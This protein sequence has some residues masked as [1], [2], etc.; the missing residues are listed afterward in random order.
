MPFA[1]RKNGRLI[2]LFT[3]ILGLLLSFV[4]LTVLRDYNPP[5]AMMV[6]IYWCLAIPNRI[7]IGT[8]WIVGLFADAMSGG[9]LLGMHA[10]SFTITAYITLSLHQRIRISPPFQQALTV[11]CLLLLYSLLIHWF[12]GFSTEHPDRAFSTEFFY[13][14]LVGFIA[15]PLLF[16][17]LRGMRRRY[18][19]S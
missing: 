8:A 4:Q 14:P 16:F 5:W 9:S 18:K 6:I 12:S 2:I 11:F 1:P 10:L 3:I 15:W 19:I 17:I 13:P 7:G